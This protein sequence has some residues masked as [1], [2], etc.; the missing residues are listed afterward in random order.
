M[1]VNKDAALPEFHEVA[2]AC[3]VF[4]LASNKTVPPSLRYAVA[5]VTLSGSSTRFEAS[6]ISKR[7]T[8]PS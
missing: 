6:R 2:A 7:R 4:R 3:P 1:P 8:P 5:S